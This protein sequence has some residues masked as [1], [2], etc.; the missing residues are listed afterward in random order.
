MLNKKNIISSILSLALGFFLVW[1]ILKFTEVDLEQVVTSFYSLN[2]LYAGLA[3]TALIVHTFLTAY[4][5]GLVTQKL[6]PDSQQASQQSLK[7]YLFYTTLGSLTM[8][9]MPQYVGMV[10]VQNLAL[11]IHKISSFS[12]GFL[13]VIYDQFF[14]F[15]IPLLLFPASILYALGYISL[16]LAIWIWIATII[17]VHFMINKW[18]RSLISF[19]I[20][21]L[22]W[23][24]QL[25]S[26]KTKDAQPAMATDKNS[27]LG[28]N[29]TL[30]LYWISVVRYL[31]WI[32]RGVLIAIAGGFKIKLWAVTFVTPIVQLAML[33]S[34]TPANL[35]LM[36]FSWIGLLRLFDVSDAIA[37]Q[38]SLMQRFLYIVAVVIVLAV[39]AV[40]SSVERFALFTSKQNQ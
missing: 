23:V 17:A 9:F 38:F 31:V 22:T 30:Y 11:R 24:K 21:A 35:G 4:K 20:A 3:I 29:F 5:W 34:F 25:K 16:S 15:L 26:G 18:H 33:F 14:N 2:P 8:Q 7:F 10:M 12:K 13:S 40:V 37:V 1:L 19:L 39:F 32:I 28:K 27:I 6:T 36:E